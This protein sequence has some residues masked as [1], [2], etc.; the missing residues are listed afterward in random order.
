MN[1]VNMMKSN[2]TLT[3]RAA[4][5]TATGAVLPLSL[6]VSAVPRSAKTRLPKTALRATSKGA[7]PRQIDSGFKLRCELNN[8]ISSFN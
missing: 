4:R 1:D 2:A 8:L 7:V 6:R 3:A 5:V